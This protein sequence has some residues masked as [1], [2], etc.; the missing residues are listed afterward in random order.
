MSPH[1]VLVIEDDQAMQDIM[2][3]I[4]TQEGHQVTTAGTVMEGL[5]R[6][7][8]EVL[9]DCIVLDLDL[10][11]GRGE[12]VLL[13]VRARGLPIHVAVCTG[14]ADPARWLKVQGLRPEALLCKPVPFGELLAACR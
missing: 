12:A 11:D 9:P 2:R 6:L 3:L 8:G 7:E 5:V 13:A 4:L 10:P 14:M 1:H